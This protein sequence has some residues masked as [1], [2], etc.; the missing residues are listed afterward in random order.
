M[1]EEV[2]ALELALLIPRSLHSRFPC[3]AWPL[4]HRFGAFLPCF[5]AFSSV[6]REVLLVLVEERSFCLIYCHKFCF[7]VLEIFVGWSEGF[8]FRV[9]VVVGLG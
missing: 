8:C 9:F 3:L 6:H 2:T 1:L 4:L 5:A 7:V